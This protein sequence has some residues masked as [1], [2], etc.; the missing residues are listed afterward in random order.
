MKKDKKN[1]ESFYS[2]FYLKII[3]IVEN[4]YNKY[5]VF[6]SVT[7]IPILIM[8]QFLTSCL[9]FFFW[10]YI[11]KVDGAVVLADSSNTNQPYWEKAYWERI[12]ATQ[13]EAT[14]RRLKEI[15][16]CSD[17]YFV[18]WYLACYDIA[19]QWKPW[20]E[21]AIHRA[22]LGVEPETIF[23][24]VDAARKYYPYYSENWQPPEDYL[25]ILR[26]QPWMDEG[27]NLFFERQFVIIGL[28]MFT[29]LTVYVYLDIT[30]GGY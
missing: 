10:I 3:T 11:L 1:K 30:G 8:Y 7:T 20:T 24:I 27:P 25:T 14:V 28:M 9:L 16:S 15:Y 26:P 4:Y 17:K 23:K 18:Y 19:F 2:K 6:Y 12:N 5:I 22:S 13:D 21:I 29:V